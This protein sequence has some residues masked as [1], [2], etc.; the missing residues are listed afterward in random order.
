MKKHYIYELV[1]STIKGNNKIH[2]LV[3]AKQKR[4]RGGLS[5]VLW[6]TLRACLAEG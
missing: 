3:E 5:L 1:E 2:K 4:N 6:S